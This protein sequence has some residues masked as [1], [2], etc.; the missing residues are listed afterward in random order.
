MHRC[1]NGLLMVQLGGTSLLTSVQTSIPLGFNSSLEWCSDGFSGAIRRTVESFVAAGVPS[2]VIENFTRKY[3]AGRREARELNNRE[4]SAQTSMA[5]AA[6]PIAPI[7]PLLPLV[8]E[9]LT[10]KM[11]V[12]PMEG[13]AQNLCSLFDLEATT[14]ALSE[15]SPISCAI[16]DLVQT[17][18]VCARDTDSDQLCTESS[19]DINIYN[20]PTEQCAPDPNTLQY[21][22][23]LPFRWSDPQLHIDLNL[24]DLLQGGASNLP[25][26]VPADVRES[27]L[28]TYL[29]LYRAVQLGSRL[30]GVC[31]GSK[32][33]IQHLIPGWK[34]VKV[35]ALTQR[36]SGGGMVQL[37]SAF[38]SVDSE[39]EC[40]I[41]VGVRGSRSGQ[42]WLS[43]FGL[44]QS[45][46][47]SVSFPTHVGVQL[48]TSDLLP[49]L[50][51][52]LEYLSAEGG[53]TCSTLEVLSA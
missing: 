51:S 29:A 15:I 35:L 2:E 27:E 40:K 22:K 32:E 16:M 53:C 47:A 50:L 42:D 52:E 8:R 39:S 28:M 4:L 17:V 13:L 49:S 25:E 21:S 34:T 41:A 30:T 23:L 36:G 19:S 33:T 45:V 1:F 18:V 12:A 6:S 26:F 44:T 14:S 7:L 3:R 43:S 46:H 48:L 37:P 31:L 24:Q 10:I 20:F 38:I 9:I 11:G 5:R